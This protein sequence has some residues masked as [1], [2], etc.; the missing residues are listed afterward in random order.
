MAMSGNYTICVGT[1]GSGAWTSPDGGETWKRAMQG[2]WSESRVFGLTAHPHEPRTVFAGADDGVYKS[3]DGG[4]SFERLDSPM[5]A[6]H[7]WKI[8]IDP[9]DPDIIFAGTRPAALFRSKDGGRSWQKLPA[10]IAAECPNVRIPRVTALTVD[11]SD[12]R[13]VWAGIEVDGVRRSTDGGDSW[14]TITNGINDPDIHDVGVFV[15]GSTIVLTTTPREIFAS[16]DR[17]E[18]W[19]GLEV[20]AQFPLPY[21]RSLVQKADDPATLFVATGDGASGSKGAIQRSTDGG[22]N[23]KM[24]SLPAEPNSPIWAFA[25]HAADPGLIIAC[26]HYGEVYASDNAGDSWKKL[27]REFTEIRAVSWTPN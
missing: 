25:T 6:L 14:Q 12:H 8:A 23:W 26:S 15:N 3:R 22:K 20:F 24:L 4:Q 16:T 1:V 13:M 18:S 17:G 5:N 27:P 11:P 9:S 2:L 10:E 21:C 7:V 19:R